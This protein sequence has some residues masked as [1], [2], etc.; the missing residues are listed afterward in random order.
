MARLD[1]IHIQAIDGPMMVHFL[2][3]VLDGKEGFRPP[4]DFPGHWVY[5]GEVPAIHISI[6]SE[7]QGMGMVSHAA[8]GVYDEAE[9]RRRIEASGFAFRVTGIPGTDIGQFFVDGP[10]GLVVEVQFRRA[11]A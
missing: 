8:F 3:L 2:E 4:F 9:A 1:H 5:L 7:P 10:E 11:A 6:V